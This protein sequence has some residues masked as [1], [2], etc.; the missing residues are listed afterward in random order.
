[1]VCVLPQPKIYINI[2]TS[3]KSYLQTPL[4][5]KEDHMFCSHHRRNDKPSFSLSLILKEEKVPS[6]RTLMPL[7][8]P[9]DH[10]A[11]YLLE[12]HLNLNFPLKT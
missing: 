8:R 4:T 6:H 11:S 12:I 10:R 2:K 9:R 1:M 5:R 7:S 3:L